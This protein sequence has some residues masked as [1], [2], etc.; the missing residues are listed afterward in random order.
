[1]VPVMRHKSTDWLVEWLQL[2]Y[3]V[4]VSSLKNRTPIMD[5]LQ[6]VHQELTDGLGCSASMGTI[7]CYKKN[8]WVCRFEF[9]RLLCKAI[10]EPIVNNKLPEDTSEWEGVILIFSKEGT[11][12]F[13]GVLAFSPWHAFILHTLINPHELLTLSVMTEPKLTQHNTTVVFG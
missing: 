7:Y 1:M 8:W 11:I 4:V 2:M 13:A 9:Q 12:A 10:V 5:S 6:L 3:L